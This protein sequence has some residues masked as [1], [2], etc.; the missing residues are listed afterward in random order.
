[1][2]KPTPRQRLFTNEFK[3][4]DRVYIIR[5]KHG[6]HDGGVEGVIADMTPHSAIV[7]SDDGID[8][9]IEHPR[10]IGKCR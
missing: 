2:S 1:M 3:V 8:Y 10:D 5:E 9:T 4:G 7:R 6:W